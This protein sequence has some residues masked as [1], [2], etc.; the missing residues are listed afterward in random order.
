MCSA[1]FGFGPDFTHAKVY[2]SDDDLVTNGYD[3]LEMTDGINI[4]TMNAWYRW[5]SAWGEVTPYVGAGLGVAVPHVEVT[6]NGSET[7]GYQL[8]G[9]AATVIAG[10]SYPVNDRWSVFGEWKS[11]YSQNEAE[12]DSGGTLE[13]DIVTNA[14]NLGVSLDF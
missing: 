4:L 7:F 9:P 1:N 5:P 8:T 13:T 6:K 11:T 12:L 3:T 14:I 10:A 2:A